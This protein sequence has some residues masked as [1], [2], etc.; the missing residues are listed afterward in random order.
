MTR[1]RAMAMWSELSSAGHPPDPDLL[2]VFL[3]WYL[4]GTACRDLVSRIQTSLEALRPLP[5]RLDTNAAVVLHLA[6]LWYASVT[7]PSPS[8][9]PPSFEERFRSWHD[10]VE[11]QLGTALSDTAITSIPPVRGLDGVEKF[12]SDDLGSGNVVMGFRTARAMANDGALG[13][14]RAFRHRFLVAQIRSRFRNMH[15]TIYRFLLEMDDRG[16][17]LVAARAASV[18][19]RF[20][21]H[22][23][24]V[25]GM[26]VLAQWG[27]QMER[28]VTALLDAALPEELG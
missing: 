26:D 2:S 24:E 18:I 7:E 23:A 12:I 17:E 5:T 13:G 11:R 21:P 16:R 1:P 19:G 9:V 3:E 28:H 22:L 25:A 27:T 8:S 6:D 20:H 14:I 15:S 4:D 10:A